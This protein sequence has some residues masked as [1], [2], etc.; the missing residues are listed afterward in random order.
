METEYWIIVGEQPT[1]PYTRAQLQTT[2]GFTPDTMVW[3]ESLTD[4]VPASQVAA[5]ADLCQ[6]VD[7]EAIKG[8]PQVPDSDT[9][10]GM[11]PIAEPE[12]EPTFSYGTPAAAVYTEAYTPDIPDADAMPARPANYLGWAI[13]SILLFFPTGII[14]LI[15][16]IKVNTHYRNL[17]LI[18]AERCSE[19]V[20]WWIMTSI[21]L[22][23]VTGPIRLLI[24]F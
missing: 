19:R 20:Q 9:V 23:L 1:G 11:P 10:P 12:A 4:W 21:V 16:A 22:A 7:T 2:P 17:D 8:M 15:Y 24:G 14:A 18:R 13:A 6:P 3:Y 5:L